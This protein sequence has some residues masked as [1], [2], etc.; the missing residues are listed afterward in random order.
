MIYYHGSRRSRL[1]SLFFLDDEMDDRPALSYMTPE[2]ST[3]QTQLLE[4]L[5][6]HLGRMKYKKRMAVVLSMVFGYVDS[7]IAAIMGCSTEAA[8]KRVQIGRRELIRGVQ[9]DSMLRGLMEEA[10]P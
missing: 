7:E 6:A 2:H 3:L 5:S 8:K 9:K 4:Q 10:N 1:K